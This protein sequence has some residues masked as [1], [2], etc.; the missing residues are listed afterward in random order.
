MRSEAA[1]CSKPCA[2]LLGQHQQRRLR[3]KAAL[4]P[5][6]S[7]AS[8]NSRSASSS[9]LQNH[10]GTRRTTPVWRALAQ[11]KRGRCRL[12]QRRR[13]RHIGQCCRSRS[14]VRAS[15][16]QRGVPPDAQ[17]RQAE[18]RLRAA[19]KAMTRDIMPATAVQQK[20]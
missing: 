5:S 15:M 14:E 2:T 9:R 16:L 4:R 1:A 6:Q 7:R 19:L 20:A 17:L 3:S 11:K 18:C 12:L 10:H 8:F 13:Q